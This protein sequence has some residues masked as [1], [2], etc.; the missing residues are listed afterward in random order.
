M[1]KRKAKRH[2]WIV[3]MVFTRTGDIIVEAADE[4]NAIEQ[5]ETLNG[6]IYDAGGQIT[7]WE[8]RGDPKPNG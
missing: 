6:K 5:A 1:A 2:S 8:V 7:D 3:P 4:E